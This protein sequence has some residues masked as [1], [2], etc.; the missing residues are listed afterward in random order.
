MQMSNEF[1]DCRDFSDSDNGLMH[2][3]LSL[4]RLEGSLS[5]ALEKLQRIH[6]LA[7]DARI[8]DDGDD[9]YYHRV[10]WT[11]AMSEA[12]LADVRARE[13]VWAQQ[14][15]QADRETYARLKARFEP[16]SPEDAGDR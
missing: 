8:V 14:A 5:D 4:T 11:L 13:A 2:F 7:P 15:E 16:G 1:D 9:G 12:D 3:A 6:A 10:R